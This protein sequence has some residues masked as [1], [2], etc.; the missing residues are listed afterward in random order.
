MHIVFLS[1]EYPLWTSGGLGTFLQTFGTTLVQHGHKVHIVGINTISKREVLKDDGVEIIRLPKNKSVIPNFLYNSKAFNKELRSI[2]KKTKIDI[3]ETP[4]SGLALLS[5]RHPAKKIIRLHGGHHFFSEAERRGINRRKAIL[6]KRS[7]RKAD[8][9][10]AI[11]E[12]V[13]EHTEKY[14]NYRNKPVRIIRNMIDTDVEIPKVT[15]RL[16]HI[17]FAGTICEKKGVRQLLEAF[18]IVRT[19]YPEVRLDLYGRDWFFPNGD[20]YIEMLHN[21]YDASFFKNVTFHGSVSRTL[22]TTKYAEASIC[23]FPSHMETQGLVSLEAMLL[24]KP[25]VFSKYG[26][27]PETIIHKETGLLCDVYNPADIAEC[28]CW[29]LEAPNKAKQIGKNA[30]ELVRQRYNKTKLLEENISFYKHIQT[31][32]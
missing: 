1:N 3:I 30:G 7:F 10:I 26:P 15:E 29:Y 28:I 4:E 25:V 23:V 5:K 16:N 22:L 2:H 19:Q 17:L 31:D 14:L 32:G 9:F 8:G 13:K 21:K 27:G 11:S 12:Y 18:K 20:S 24:Y 6:E